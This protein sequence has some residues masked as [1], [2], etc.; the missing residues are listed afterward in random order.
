[1]NNHYSVGAGFFTVITKDRVFR[2]RAR[3]EAHVRTV[4]T[5]VDMPVLAVER[6]DELADGTGS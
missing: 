2:V 6:D 5:S 1:M 3:S 4:F